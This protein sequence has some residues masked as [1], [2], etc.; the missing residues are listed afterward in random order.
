M[1]VVGLLYVYIFF[2]LHLTVTKVDYSGLEST[3]ASEKSLV[4]IFS[5]GLL[6]AHS[7][8]W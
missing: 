7:A 6:C 4:H 3:E 8:A 5:G 2:F 1:Y